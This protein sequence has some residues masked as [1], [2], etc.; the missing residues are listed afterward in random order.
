MI[1][2]GL[3]VFSKYFSLYP[4]CYCLIGGTALSLIYQERGLPFRATKDLDVVV[5]LNLKSPAFI[6]KIIAFVQE[7]AYAKGTVSENHCSFRFSNPKEGYPR[8]IELFTKEQA[9]GL[10]LAKN[11]EHLNLDQEVSFSA[12]VLDP[13]YYDYI[14]SNTKQGTPSYISDYSIVP[15][16]AKA[17]L[18]NKELFKKGVKGI[19]EKTYRKHA[20]DIIRF[21]FVFEENPIV[22]PPAIKEDCRLFLEAIETETLDFGAIVGDPGFDREHFVQRFRADYLN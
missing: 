11:L 14:A 2:K 10:S 21:I 6:K 3:E 5:L 8:T 12:I 22:L 17:Y 18:G 16:K 4:D 1:I 7:G 13:V 15:L 20:Y 19:D 9:I